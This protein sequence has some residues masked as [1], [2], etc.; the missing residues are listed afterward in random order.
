MVR[1]S[2][3]AAWLKHCRLG[4]NFFAFLANVA[5]GADPLRL[6]PPG[7]PA[8]EPPSYRVGRHPPPN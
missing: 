3:I 8:P 5:F 2:F 6:P 1:L 7:R 4:V